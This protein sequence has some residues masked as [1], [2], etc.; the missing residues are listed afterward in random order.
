MNDNKENLK[1]DE[2]DVALDK[3]ALLEIKELVAVAKEFE[4][5]LN[6]Y[7][8]WTTTVSMA[9]FAFYMTALLQIKAIVS[10]LPHA[11]ISG[12]SLIFI[13]VSVFLGIIVRF[14]S[15]FWSLKILLSKLFGELSRLTDQT[16]S[17]MVKENGVQSEKSKKNADVLGI[18]TVMFKKF[19]EDI[20]K[21]NA[22]PYGKLFVALLF[23]Q[24]VSLIVGLA[25]MLLHLGLFLYS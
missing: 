2:P 22:N 7:P 18:T 6:K 12:I 14:R 17:V 25:F 4:K 10:P 1:S 5:Y 20:K 8:S 11:H 3:K 21:T 13:T 16:M 15:E 19:N 23:V 9:L 24:G